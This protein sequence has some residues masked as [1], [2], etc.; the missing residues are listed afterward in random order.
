MPTMQNIANNAYIA[1][2][3][4]QLLQALRPSVR[5]VFILSC[6]ITTLGFANLQGVW[7]PIRLLHFVVVQQR[8]R[9]KTAA[10]TTHQ[11]QRC[12][13]AFKHRPAHATQSTLMI[14]ENSSFSDDVWIITNARSSSCMSMSYLGKRYSFTGNQFDLWR[15]SNLYTFW[16]PI[17]SVDCPFHSSEKCPLMFS[18]S[19]FSSGR[20]SMID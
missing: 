2:N 18:A 4:L 10:D 6:A 15:I 3:L 17:F 9:R 19:V 16:F 5:T 7:I 12:R 11:Q 1:L 14:Y 13:H 8:S 20:H